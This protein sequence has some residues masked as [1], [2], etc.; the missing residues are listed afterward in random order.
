L[1]MKSIFYICLYKT[2]FFVIKLY[3][4]D[5]ERKKENILQE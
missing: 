1:N 4:L 5:L 2:F 3:K